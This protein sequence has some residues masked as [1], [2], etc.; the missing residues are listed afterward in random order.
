[1]TENIRI[2]ETTLT[3]L[4][5]WVQVADGKIAPILAIDTSMLAVFAA[6]VPKASEWSVFSAI[7]AL[8]ATLPLGVSLLFL[9]LAS[10]PRTKGPKRSL[11]YFEG[12]KTC[13][14]AKYSQD[15][16]QL[17]PECYLDDLTEQCHRNAEIVSVKFR[18]LSVAMVSL[19]IS[20]IPWLLIVYLLYSRK[21]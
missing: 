17:T 11:I 6:L 3:R 19:F 2:A 16:K 8:L 5:H 1:M 20:I 10:F 9:F 21:T 18:Y 12:I 13:E 15:M 7:V 14:R 4:L